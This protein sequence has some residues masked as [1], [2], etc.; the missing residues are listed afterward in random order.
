MGDPYLFLSVAAA[1][2]GGVSIYGGQGSYI[3]VIGGALTLTLLTYLFAAFQLGA[4][5]SDVAFGVIVGLIVA[6]TAVRRRSGTRGIPG[7]QLLRR[8]AAKSAE[9]QVSE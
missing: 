8:R 5:A 1:V 2:V 3:G 9:G 7:L 4:A 6:I